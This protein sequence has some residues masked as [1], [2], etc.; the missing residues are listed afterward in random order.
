[1]SYKKDKYC[2]IR[3]AIPKEIANFVYNYFLIKEKV[4]KTMTANKSIS[5]F[6][7]EFGVAGDV[8]APD[9]Y[10]CYADGAMETLLLRCQPVMEKNTGLK[11]LPTYSYARIYKTGSILDRHKDR[12]SCEISTT[13]FLGGDI[14]PI[15]LSPF[16]NVGSTVGPNT[17]PG[18]TMSSKAKGVKVILKQ[19]DM[20][21]YDGMELEHWRERFTE[22]TCVQ[23]FLHYNKDTPT[24]QA[25]Q[26]DT[27]PHLGLPAYFQKLRKFVP[28]P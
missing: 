2:I 15:Y 1:M 23:V 11:L 27:R 5:P 25:N 28:N 16:E 10:S 18:A 7:E 8:Q 13:L 3:K 20:L 14:W 19:G 22:K 4:F 12:K 26:F 21:A 9:T 6:S 17:V 24:N